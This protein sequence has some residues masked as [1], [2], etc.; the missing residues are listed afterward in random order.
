MAEFPALNDQSVSF[1]ILQN[2]ARLVNAT[3]THPRAAELLFL[4]YGVLDIGFIDTTNKPYTQRLQAGDIFVFR[5][6]LCQRRN[7]VSSN[8]GVPHRIDDAILAKSFKADAA[9][10]QK[11]KA[12]LTPHKP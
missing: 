2:P 5:K 4:I 9:T 1:A 6:G 3:H 7:R 12:G 10:I 11:L 8:F